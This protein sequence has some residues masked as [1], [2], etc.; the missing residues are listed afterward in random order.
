MTDQLNIWGNC[1][2]Y[3]S[4]ILFTTKQNSVEL[5]S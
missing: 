2:A 3:G 4:Y 1:N 5:K